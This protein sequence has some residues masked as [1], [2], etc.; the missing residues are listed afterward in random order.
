MTHTNPSSAPAEPLLGVGAI[1]AA[2]TALLALLVA[3]GIH[4]TDAQ[5]SAVLG[6]LAAL[7]PLVTAWLGRGRVYSPRTVARLLADARRNR[8]APPTRLP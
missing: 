2:V 1:V 7:A 8:S 6:F 4:L 5:Q 3:F